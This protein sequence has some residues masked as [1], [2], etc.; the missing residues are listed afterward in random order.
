M[1]SIIIVLT[2]LFIGGTVVADTVGVA[3]F[4]TVASCKEERW[5]DRQP[6]TASGRPL[7]DSIM[8]CALPGRPAKW[9]EKWLVTNTNT[10]K[11]ITVE[12]WDIGPNRHC[13][14][15]HGVVIDLTLQAFLNLGGNVKDGKIAVK[16]ER[17]K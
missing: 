8:G 3:T 13:I 9:G 7:N 6:L 16:I 4:Y 11:S 14:V 5:G 1:K 2:A 17:V 15:E 12:Q 10:G